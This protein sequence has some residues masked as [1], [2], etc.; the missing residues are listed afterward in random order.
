MGVKERKEREFRRREEEILSTAYRL[1]AEMEPSQ[2]T[3]EQ[4]AEQAEIGRGTIYKHFKSKDEIYAKLI[5]NR[6]EK[7]NQKL[8]QIEKEGIERIPRLVRAYMDYC[9]EDR[10]AYAV[11]KKCDAHC[12]RQNLSPEMFD[13]LNTQQEVKIDLVKKILLKALGETASDSEDLVYYI[14]SVW[15]MQKGAI[16]AFLDNRFEGAQL[17]EEKYF[18][19]VEQTFLS[20]VP[21]RI[22]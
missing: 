22:Q 12:V 11:H 3:M 5:L 18:K 15:G 1:L 8:E 21:L 2:M 6:R 20:G 10:E 14:C 9:L 19:I 17:E 16:D 7:L 13:S 4:I